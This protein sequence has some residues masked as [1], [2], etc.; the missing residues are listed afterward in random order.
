MRVRSHRSD[1]SPGRKP[2]IAEKICE[3]VGCERRGSCPIT[4]V[5]RTVLLAE[6]PAM[7]YLQRRALSN[8]QRA[9]RPSVADFMVKSAHFVF[10]DNVR[11]FSRR[12][13][14]F[15]PLY[16]DPACTS[17]NGAGWNAAKKL[18]FLSLFFL[19]F[20]LDC[21]RPRSPGEEG[22]HRTDVKNRTRKFEGL[23]RENRSYA[24]LRSRRPPSRQPGSVRAGLYAR[25]RK[26]Y[27]ERME[28][29]G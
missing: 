1:F 13:A 21:V 24:M 19:S 26:L 7:V 16:G 12:S 20:S 25:T 4:Q 17:G 22:K 10:K 28:H 2:A 27:N 5:R 14:F 11:R 15:R 6:K 9:W 23:D 8:L 29:Y 3:K 18:R